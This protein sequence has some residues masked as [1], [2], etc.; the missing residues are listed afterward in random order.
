MITVKWLRD[1]LKKLIN[2][3]DNPI[4]NLKH[5]LWRDR[6]LKGDWYYRIRVP[7]KNKGYYGFEVVLYKKANKI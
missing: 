4:D 1:R 3:V 6:H 5:W 7:M 2:L